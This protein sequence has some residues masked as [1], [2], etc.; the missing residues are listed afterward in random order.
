VE[1]TVRAG[2][3]NRYSKCNANVKVVDLVKPSIT[4]RAPLTTNVTAGFC[5][6]SIFYELPVVKD[7]C[8]GLLDNSTQLIDGKGNSGQFEVGKTIEKYKVTDDAGNTAEC[9]FVVTVNH[10]NGTNSQCL[11][12]YSECDSDAECGDTSKYGCDENKLCALRDC[13]PKKF[14]PTVNEC[15]VD[16]D[17]FYAVDRCIS[18]LCVWKGIPSFSLKWF[19]DGKND[20]ALLLPQFFFSLFSAFLA[21]DLDLHVITPNGNEIFWKNTYADYGWLEKDA[22]NFTTKASRVENIYFPLDGSS[23]KGNYTYWVKAHEPLGEPEQYKLTAYNGD[24]AV[25]SDSGVLSIG[26]ES[27]RFRY[28]LT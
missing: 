19:G 16:S 26:K 20:K 13:N 8:G 18:N 7:N 23:L 24:S 12:L 22:T 11:E 14:K 10:P 25:A 17:C 1:L 6:K 3:P 4:C 27:E 15:C 28:V 21:D 9:S 2:N 5:S